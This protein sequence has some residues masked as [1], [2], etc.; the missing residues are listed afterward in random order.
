MS[1]KYK[2]SQ[3]RGLKLAITTAELRSRGWNGRQIAKAVSEGKLFRLY[4][5]VYV[6]QRPTG[7]VVL[8]ALSEV[9]GHV[10]AAGRTAVELYLGQEPS[11]PVNVVV[12]RG[13]SLPHSPYV[14]ARRSRNTR[15]HYAG[16][17]EKFPAQPMLR[18]LDEAL[19]AGEDR[20][21]KKLETLFK[22]KRGREL[23]RREFRRA[24]RVSARLRR[25]IGMASIG[26]DSELEREVFRPL[27]ADGLKV[28]QNYWL[29]GYRFDG[30]VG[31]R[32]LLEVDSYDYHHANDPKRETYDTFIR[33]RFKANL[34]QR[35]GYVVL[36]FSDAD[37]RFHLGAVLRVVKDTVRTMDHRPVGA[38]TL[39]PEEQKQVWNWH[40]GIRQYANA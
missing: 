36:R 38:A 12:A 10:Y 5:G 24:G 25:L 31:Q 20:I 28:Q 33:D 27:R 35:L 18:A 26:A 30:L 17:G 23:L 14:H 22:G 4:K 29:G 34:A 37:V 8:K 13:R 19:A 21:L 39:Q 1:G 15:W 3:H 40:F 9:K 16:D 32:V 2:K 7:R 11:L 6:A